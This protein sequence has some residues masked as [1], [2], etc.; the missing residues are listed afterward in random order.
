MDNIEMIGLF[1]E[2]T[3][4]N[5]VLVNEYTPGQGIMVCTYSSVFKV[6]NYT[7]DFVRF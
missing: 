7:F 3:K 4:L 6:L 2:K 5:H 1:N